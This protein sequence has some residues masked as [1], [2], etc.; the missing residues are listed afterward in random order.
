MEHNSENRICQNCKNS[1]VIEP[2]DFGFY[3]KMGVPAPSLCPDCR[4]KR[5]AI[6]R[7]ETTLYTDRKCAKCGKSIVSM[8]NPE[9]S[10]IV[11]CY[12]CYR[13]DSWD[14]R[15]YAMDYN[16]SKPFFE[17]LGELFKKV[18]KMTTYITTGLG[19][20][21]NSEYT[22]TAGGNKNC[23]MVFNSGLNE[24]VMYSRGVI[25][26]KDSLDLYFS[27]NIELGYELINT[28]KASR[29][30]W[31]RN[32]PACLDSAFMLNCSG[33]TSCFG[34]VNLRNKSYHFFNQLLSKEEYK[35]RV[36]KIMGS[37]SEMEK[38]RKE[39]ETFS[40]KFP[41]RENNNLKTVNC[42]GDYITEGKNLFNCFEV[43][44]AE[45]CK[46]MFATK[47]IKDSY[48]V[49]GHGLRSELL[50]ECN[51][52]GISSRIIGSSNIENGN[53]LEYCCFLTP[54]NKYCFGCNSLRNAEYCI[55]NKQYTKEEYEKLREKIIAELKSK[56]LY[57]LFM[58]PE[59]SPFAYNE[60]VAQDNMPLTKEE[61][62]AQGFRWKDNLQ[63]TEGRETLKPD[64]I[65]DHIKDIGD[66]IIEEILACISCNRNYKIV[67]D[68]LQFYRR[69][70][71]PLPRKCFFCRHTDRILRRGPMKFWNRHCV[72]CDKKII[73]N[74]A[75][76]RPEIVYCEK[77]YQQEVY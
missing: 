26:S 8:Y 65:P 28:H 5:R 31:S 70:N 43:A 48:D 29:I 20:N 22:N 11:Y 47:K 27:N 44:E 42:V 72:K 54:N 12:D 23:Y 46:N 61:A 50:L 74:Y 52:V 69:M 76:D 49:L 45:N 19:S 32:S 56:N 16:E 71:L 77:C 55:L 10:Y 2:E 34:C 53:N 39:F 7:N 21:V 64:Q 14:P 38:F 15:D 75:P 25:N 59:L 33:C 1:F 66:N 24:N 17:Q 51:G 36:D 68:E 13:S 4:F 30:I 9:L 35:E 18:P 40:L 41:R 60:T 57:G 37:Y 63:K 3:E 62:L 58:P 6:G 67:P 73:T